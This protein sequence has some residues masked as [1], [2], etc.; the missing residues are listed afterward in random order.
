MERFWMYKFFHFER[1]QCF[2]YFCL[3]FS[4]S[5][6]VPQFGLILSF[7]V[8][9]FYVFMYKDGIF[10]HSC[11]KCSYYIALHVD[12]RYLKHIILTFDWYYTYPSFSSMITYLL[13]SNYKMCKEKVAF[14][15]FKV[16]T[17]FIGKVMLIIIL[18]HC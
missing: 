11:F 14:G 12:I 17:L 18:C 5:S 10:I 8:V 15:S 3:T 2:K 7:F 1:F 4:I 13:F 6:F 16:T 9:K